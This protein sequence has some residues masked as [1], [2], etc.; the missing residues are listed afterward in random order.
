[1]RTA[2]LL[3]GNNGQWS[4][5]L[6][7]GEPISNASSISQASFLLTNRT[8]SPSPFAKTTGGTALSDASFGY[9]GFGHESTGGDSGTGGDGGGDGGGVGSGL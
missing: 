7:G 8:Q 3:G 6:G 9:G 4:Q 5:T 2:S 1:M